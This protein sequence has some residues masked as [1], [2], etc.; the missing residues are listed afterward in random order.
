MS[1]KAA[2]R[3]SYINDGNTE[4]DGKVVYIPNKTAVQNTLSGM[5][6]II[7]FGAE[8]AKMT[9]TSGNYVDC[10]LL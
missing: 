2:A 10:T 5:S 9:M 8:T 7:L 3:I 4:L 6:Y 1:A